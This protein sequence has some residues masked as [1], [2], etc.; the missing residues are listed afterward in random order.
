VL[1]RG[2][3]VEQGTVRDVFENPQHEY[4]RTLLDAIPRVALDTF[5]I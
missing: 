2:T 5:A 3:A 4:T 1:Q